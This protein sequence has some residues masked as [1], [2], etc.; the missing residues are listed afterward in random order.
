MAYNWVPPEGYLLASGYDAEPRIAME[1]AGGGT[2]DYAVAPVAV[3]LDRGRLWLSGAQEPAYGAVGLAGDYYPPPFNTHLERSPVRANA[4]QTDVRYDSCVRTDQWHR[5]VGRQGNFTTYDLIGITTSLL[6]TG[7]AEYVTLT[8]QW[9]VTIPMPT[10]VNYAVFG[11]NYDIYYMVDPWTAPY[12]TRYVISINDDLGSV[13]ATY[14]VAGGAGT[15]AIAQEVPA[16]GATYWVFGIGMQ[17]RYEM[18]DF[19]GEDFVFIGW[20]DWL[21]MPV[22]ADMGDEFMGTAA[23]IS[24]VTGDLPLYIPAAP[25]YGSAFVP[26]HL[27]EPVT[28]PA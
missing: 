9:P 2:T 25:A 16:P 14:V 13:V 19:V 26:A 18:W 24:P 20:S 1:S 8:F 28:L 5:N 27:S 17:A 4:D 21:N 3:V 6:W 23:C 22:G 7:W 12:E 10:S 11:R 15:Q